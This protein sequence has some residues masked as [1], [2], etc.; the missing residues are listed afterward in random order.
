MEKLIKVKV[1]PRAKF[2]Q[3]LEDLEGNLKVKLKSPPLDGRANEELIELYKV[4]KRQIEIVKGK[5]S[6]QKVIKIIND[7]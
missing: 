5:L 1:T 7:K 2:V 6:R 4:A 3:I